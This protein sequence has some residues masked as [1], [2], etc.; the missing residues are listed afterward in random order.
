MWKQAAAVILINK[1]KTALQHGSTHKFNY[2]ILM[3]ERSTKSQFMPN[4]YVFPG[5]KVSKRDFNNE[6]QLL[7]QDDISTIP[8]TRLVHDSQHINRSPMLTAHSLTSVKSN[9]AYRICGVRET[10]EESGILMQKSA[11]GSSN[12]AYSK[13]LHDWRLSINKDDSKF[14]AMFNDLKITPDICSLHEWNNWLTPTH[15]AKTHG[16]RRFDTIFYMAFMEKFIEANHDDEEIIAS[17]VM[18]ETV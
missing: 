2:K 4:A 5:G 9:I 13:I 6:W 14:I 11:A 12:P 1:S 15:L 17:K 7:L 16:S 8:F 18:Y 3:L 10:F